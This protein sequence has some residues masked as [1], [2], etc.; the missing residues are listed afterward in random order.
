MHGRGAQLQYAIRVSFRFHSYMFIL[1]FGFFI[2]DSIPLKFGT[3]VFNCYRE[4][5]HD[6]RPHSQFPHSRGLDTN[7]PSN[8]LISSVSATKNADIIKMPHCGVPDTQQSYGSHPIR[9]SATV[10]TV[11][12][13]RSRTLPTYKQICWRY[14][15]GPTSQVNHI[16]RAQCT[17]RDMTMAQSDAVSCWKLIS[18]RM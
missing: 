6:A 15:R 4:I 16:T 8:W 5:L 7:F 3:V 9:H 13:R 2:I 12:L 17:F 10:P 18:A 14:A 1:H 11:G